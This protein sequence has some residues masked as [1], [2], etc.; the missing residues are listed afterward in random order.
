MLNISIFGERGNY[1]VVATGDVHFFSLGRSRA[2]VTVQNWTSAPE[3]F[4]RSVQQE[5]HDSE[6]RRV[7]GD[8]HC[9]CLMG[10]YELPIC[11][12]QKTP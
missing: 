3:S 7:V 5:S 6:Q 8:S 2:G 9:D 12:M 4:P 11:L 1:C 10:D